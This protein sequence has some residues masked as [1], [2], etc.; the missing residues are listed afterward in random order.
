MITR[1]GTMEVRV[2]RIAPADF[3]PELFQRYQRSEKPLV[4]A[5]AEM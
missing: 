4:G 1:A 3:R 2:R 5:L